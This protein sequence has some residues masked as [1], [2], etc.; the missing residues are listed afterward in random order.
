VRSVHPME[1]FVGMRRSETVQDL[2]AVHTYTG[3]LG[4][5]AIRGVERDRQAS[6]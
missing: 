2:T 1:A 5:C 6:L 4:T 3:E